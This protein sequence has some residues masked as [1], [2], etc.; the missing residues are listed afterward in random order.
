MVTMPV[1]AC[2]MHTFSTFP[3]MIRHSTGNLPNPSD[4]ECHQYILNS[5]L[6]MNRY[7]HCTQ[8]EAI[9]LIVNTEKLFF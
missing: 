4:Y 3:N 2:D 8:Y 9:V 5:G 6:I 1:L 7:I